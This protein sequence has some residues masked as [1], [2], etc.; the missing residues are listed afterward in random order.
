[1]THSVASTARP[2]TIAARPTRRS[3]SL[4]L[5]EDEE[6]EDQ[7]REVR[8]EEVARDREREERER[9]EEVPALADVAPAERPRQR[10]RPHRPELRP[11]AAADPHVALVLVAVAG[12]AR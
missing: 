2:P 10:Q 1:M 11:Q 8:G 9:A 4:G 12:D 3:R 6:D 7:A 5:Q